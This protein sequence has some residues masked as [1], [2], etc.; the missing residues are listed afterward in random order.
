MTVTGTTV[1]RYVVSPVVASTITRDEFV[2][3]VLWVAH[4]NGWVAVH[5]VNRHGDA[6]VYDGAGFPTLT[7]IHSER[8]LV[9]FREV[10]GHNQ[11]AASSTE[12]WYGVLVDIGANVDIWRPADWPDVVASLTLGWWRVGS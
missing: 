3:R 5:A 1:P 9:W 10:L 6:E 7:L 11:R 2:E 12:A 4:Q 8:S